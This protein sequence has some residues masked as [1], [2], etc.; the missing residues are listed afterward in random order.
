MSASEPNQS[1]D[2]PNSTPDNTTHFGYKTIDKEDKV[3]MVA[4]VFHSVAKQYDVMND[5]MSFGIH[6]LSFSVI[7]F[8]V[9]TQKLLVILRLRPRHWLFW[10]SWASWLLA[11]WL[12]NILI[13][14]LACWFTGFC[15][16][17][18]VPSC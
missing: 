8:P 6:L 12:G 16:L 5:L 14:L 4:G 17:V 3:S 2:T 13:G 10:Q 11:G 18:F 15:C 7:D 1:S 9:T